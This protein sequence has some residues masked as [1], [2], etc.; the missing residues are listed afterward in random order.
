[1]FASL[2]EMPNTKAKVSKGWWI[3]CI[4]YENFYQ[5]YVSYSSEARSKIQSRNTKGTEC[6]S[7]YKN[8]A[9]S[10][11]F[12][13]KIKDRKFAIFHP[14]CSK[15]DVCCSKPSSHQERI[16]LLTIEDGTISETILENLAKSCDTQKGTNDKV[17]VVR[18]MAPCF[19]EVFIVNSTYKTNCIKTTLI[20]VEGARN[21]CGEKLCLALIA[22]ESKCVGEY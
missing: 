1:M 19:P 16:F 9:L 11:N 6:L 18:K 22:A 3:T 15:T 10:N 20:C 17:A 5:C 2:L 13:C 4:I 8:Y 12:T 21:L 7:T 14:A